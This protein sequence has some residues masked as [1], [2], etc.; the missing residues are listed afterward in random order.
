MA[1]TRNGTLRPKQRLAATMAAILTSLLTLS[2]CAARN[3]NFVYQL[4]QIDS[5]Y[6]LLPPRAES[7]TDRQIIRIPSGQADAP[8]NCSIHGTWFSLDRTPGSRLWNAQAPS[9]SAWQ[10]SG[11]TVDL[12]EEWEVFVLAL[13]GLEQ[14][15]C[16]PSPE[17]YFQV[18]Q[19][20]A[21]SLPVPAD[22]ALFYRYG[23]GIGG[24]VTL[25]PGMQL[26]IERDFY[27][28]GEG[29][30][31]RVEDY[32]GTTITTYAVVPQTGNGTLLKFLRVDKRSSVSSVPQ[33]TTK[34]TNLAK[35]LAGFP[36][37]RLFLEDLKVS[38]DAN[39]PAILLGGVTEDDLTA[40]SQLIQQNPQRCNGPVKT[41]VV[42][43]L[44]A[45]PVTVSP[46]LQ[47]T[48][49]RSTEY[50][51]IGS[52]LLSTLP[53]NLDKE[54]DLLKTLHI[55]RPFRGKLTELRIS[56][57]QDEISQV[58]LFGGDRI[59]WSKKSNKKR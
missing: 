4:K 30:S 11:G 38:A 12:K 40:A 51:P 13:H 43:L 47:V 48:V 2:G 56:R 46:M 57:S 7:P 54:Q 55:E 5:Q 25:T 8:A 50:F 52:K 36:H 39:T 41:G 33:A 44:F 20:I 1:P 26:R 10:R 28:A 18:R 14:R 45:G 9:A 42:C 31:H 24:Y 23:Y 58:L 22:E 3:P 27:C 37:I 17:E 35:E 49:N 19:T 32:R 16:F 53:L 59:T 6:F 34:D 21:E 29:A 15:H